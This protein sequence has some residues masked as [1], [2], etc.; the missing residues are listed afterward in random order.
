[1]AAMSTCKLCGLQY[2]TSAGRLHGL[3]FKCKLCDT[4]ERTIRRNL[5]TNNGL[6]SFTVS[7]THTFF[8]TLHE[9]KK[10]CASARLQWHTVRASLVTSMTTK[11]ITSFRA[12]VKGK[13][14]PLCVWKAQ[15]WEEETVL[16]CPK[17]WS[18]E[19]KTDTYL[20]PIKV[21]SWAE[22]HEQHMT[23]VLQQEQEITKK[24][25]GRKG[26]D[27][28]D[29]DLDVPDAQKEGKTKEPSAKSLAA[30][31]KRL[32]TQG[33][34]IGS[35]AAKALGPLRQA[36]TSLERVWGKAQPHKAELPEGLVTVVEE[37][38][39]KLQSWTAAA[40]RSLEAAESCK[41][42]PEDA[43]LTEVPQLPF[44]PE[45]LKASVKQAAEVQKAVRDSLPKKEP[46]AK[47][48]SKKK[49]GD[50][51]ETG[52]EPKQ[53]RKR[54]TGKTTEAEKTV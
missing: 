52:S 2:E 16:N 20:V 43:E 13:Y 31:R 28:E 25:G 23:K 18:E 41:T 11:S 19:L 1:M 12:E 42:I 39:P 29:G 45:D 26:P 30:A 54:V 49:A 36:V 46:K 51:P 32:F 48:A 21:L 8:R 14:L 5:G 53:K 38:L 50:S 15:G 24:R 17:E 37:T 6:Q 44:A 33:Q 22:Q 35:K 7:E 4:S 47:A 10:K 34:A 27:S 9:E 3:S 40:R